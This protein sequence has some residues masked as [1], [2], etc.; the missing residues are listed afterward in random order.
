[1][2]KYVPDILSG[3]RI[4]GALAM[5]F[6]RT[7]SAPFYVLYV[8]CGVSDIAD[9][10]FARKFNAQSE[11]GAILDSAAD[12]LFFAVCAV[13]LWNCFE[14]KTYVIAWA[15]V[16]AAVKIFVTAASLHLPEMRHCRMNRL[17]GLMLFCFAPFAAHEAVQCVL[18]TAATLA[19]TRELY[20]LGRGR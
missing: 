9:G 3:M 12:F 16:I 17:T 5:I 14:F 20:L 7:F 2:K 10:F 11:I 6:Q 15:E 18:C 8:F 13:K 19:A 4:A 1:M